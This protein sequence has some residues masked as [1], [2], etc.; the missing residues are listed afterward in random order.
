MIY[1]RAA[2]YAI[3]AFV[4]LAEREQGEYSLVKDIAERTGAPMH[5][6][7]KILQQLT[8]RGWVRSNKG[9]TGGFRLE[10]P[11]A[12]INLLQIVEAIDG[13]EDYKRCISGFPECNDQMPCGMHDS[14]KRLRSAIMGYLEQTSIA[15][16]AQAAVVKRRN[17]KARRSRRAAAKRN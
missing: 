17:E 9:R 7:S 13:T 1:S 16:L 2:E 6:L 14:W 8:R 3:R 11:A 12:D 15:D 10:S 5:F 4:D